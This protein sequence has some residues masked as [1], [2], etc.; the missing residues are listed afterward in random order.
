MGMKIILASK[1]PRRKELLATIFE[2]FE[3]KPSDK[4]EE[5]TK[6]T[7]IKNIAKNI[8][9]QKA[10]DIFSKTEGDRVI[11]GSDTMVVLGKRIFGKPKNQDE[12]FSMLKSLSG[13]THKVV[14]GI[15]VIKFEG[16]TKTIVSDVVV[17]KVK[18]AKMSDKEIWDYIK[19]GDPMDKAGAYGCQGLAKK[20]IE[21][22]DGDFFAVMG[23]PVHKTYE[24]CKKLSIID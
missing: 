19:T 16:Q 22:I 4:S 15:Y 24:I 21:K 8:S 23:L 5:M 13:R 7:S 12:A 11:I 2:E 6:K 20:Y 9:G 1:S 18:F 10:E 3:C 14:T 17:S